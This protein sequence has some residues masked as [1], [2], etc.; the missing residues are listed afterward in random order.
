MSSNIS[1]LFGAK[2]QIDLSP[3]GPPA[4][5]PSGPITGPTGNQVSLKP[6][7]WAGNCHL[8]CLMH[9]CPRNLFGATAARNSRQPPTLYPPPPPEPLVPTPPFSGLSVHSTHLRSNT[10]QTLDTRWRDGL[11]GTQ[12]ENSRWREMFAPYRFHSSARRLGCCSV[13]PVKEFC[14]ILLSVSSCLRNSCVC[15]LA[16]S[17]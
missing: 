14:S 7:T 17:T 9:S 10:S 11:N 12:S 3:P 6:I 5:A 1:G 8:A 13:S 15:T 16:V 2:K 4:L